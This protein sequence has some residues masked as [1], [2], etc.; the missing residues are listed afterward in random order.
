MENLK[1]KIEEMVDKVKNDPKKAVDDIIRFSDH[2]INPLFKAVVDSTEEA[3]LNSMLNATSEVSY[4]GIRYKSLM[5]YK[6]LFEDLLINK[7]Q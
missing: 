2:F 4:N 1:E 7:K 6:K 5:E 3:V